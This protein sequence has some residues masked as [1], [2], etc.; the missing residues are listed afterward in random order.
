MIDY[1]L[2]VI[3]DRDLPRNRTLIEVIE[4]VI[5]GRHNIQLREKT[6]HGSFENAERFEKLPKQL[7]FRDH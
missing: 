7:E 2:Y 3:T 6:F 1:S 4:E 5:R